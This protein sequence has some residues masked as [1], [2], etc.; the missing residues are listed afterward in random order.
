METFYCSQWLFQETFQWSCK[1]SEVWET[2]IAAYLSS[3]SHI[4]AYNGCHSELFLLAG[5]EDS[6]VPFYSASNCE[7]VSVLQHDA[8]GFT[9]FQLHRC[10][11]NSVCTASKP[12]YIVIILYC[13]PNDLYCDL[14]R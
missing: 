11:R 8:A 1:G 6:F 9:S 5:M 14:H 7:C 4:F 12:I 13:Y 3:V 2:L 10:Y